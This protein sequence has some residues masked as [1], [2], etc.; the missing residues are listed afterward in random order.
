MVASILVTITI[1][2]I[3]VYKCIHMLLLSKEAQ[4]QKLAVELN[5]IIQNIEVGIGIIH[6]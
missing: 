4:K 5:N 3:Q 1:L 6:H 2:N